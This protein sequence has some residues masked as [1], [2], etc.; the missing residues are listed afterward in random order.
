[1]RKEKGAGSCK[2]LKV[3]WVGKGA[4][5]S[6]AVHNKGGV[7]KGGIKGVLSCGLIGEGATPS[8]PNSATRKNSILMSTCDAHRDFFY[9]WHELGDVTNYYI[10]LSS[11]LS[12]HK[13]VKS[14]C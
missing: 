2:G 10:V 4:G 1:M 11:T 14:P 7:I 5:R 12:I 6:G 13:R 8:S 9:G 3:V